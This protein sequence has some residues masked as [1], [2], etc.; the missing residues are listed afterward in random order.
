MGGVYHYHH[1]S[2]TSLNFQ[3]QENGDLHAF[4]R[5][6]IFFSLSLCLSARVSKKIERERKPT[7]VKRNLKREITFVKK[8]RHTIAFSANRAVTTKQRT[9]KSNC[10]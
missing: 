10:V 5:E 4:S 2:Q 1:L 3:V 8:R 9:F 6:I 7:R